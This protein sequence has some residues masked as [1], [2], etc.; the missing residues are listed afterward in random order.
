M[1]EEID[2]N[3]RN[4]SDLCSFSQELQFLNEFWCTLR[5]SISD[6]RAWNVL[7]QKDLEANFSRMVINWKYFFLCP[8]H[9]FAKFGCSQKEKPNHLEH[10]MYVLIMGNFFFHLEDDT[11]KEQCQAIEVIELGWLCKWNNI[12]FRRNFWE[13]YRFLIRPFN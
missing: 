6:W 5:L 13:K 2:E 1:E 3:G 7:S 12:I 4:T 10:D 9:S 8:W 11:L